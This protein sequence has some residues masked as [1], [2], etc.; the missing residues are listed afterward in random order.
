MG[1]WNEYQMSKAS[2]VTGNDTILLYDFE[3]QDMKQVDITTFK[4][5]IRPF[6]EE[7]VEKGMD[8]FKEE[9]DKDLGDVWKEV[10][11]LKK[12]QFNEPI[13]WTLRTGIADDG[14]TALNQYTAVSQPLAVEGGSVYIYDG[15]IR[16]ASRIYFIVR[17]HFYSDG[18]Y[19]GK[20]G[21]NI[22][23]EPITVPDGT[24][25]VIIE[26]GRAK[27]DL[28]TIT[29]NDIDI[30]YKGEFASFT[31]MAKGVEEVLGIPKEYTVT[32][33]DELLQLFIDL[34][35]DKKEKTVYLQGGEYDIFN[36]YKTLG[37]TSPPQGTSTSNYFDYNVF[38]PLNTNIIG[39]G[40]VV[41]KWMPTSSEISAL[42]SQIWCPVNV[43]GS[44]S[45]ENITI[46]VKN[47]R[48]C[49]HDD[50]HN[51][52]ADTVHE[53]KN[54]ICIFEAPDEGYTLH[55][56]IGFGFDPRGRYLF[57]GCTFIN[58][59][60]G[61]NHS[62]FYGHGSTSASQNPAKDS[63]NV[64]V[65]DCV[66]KSVGANTVRLQTITAVREHIKTL[67]SN[68]YISRNVL[69]TQLSSVAGAKN[70]FDLTLLHSGSPSVNVTDTTNPYEVKIYQ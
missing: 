67:F 2:E 20:A 28:V 36:A 49:I 53:Y 65:K 22:N 4:T 18:E 66:I 31:Q 41:L 19:I 69:L 58:L 47:A 13:S 39:R 63:A 44:I 30:Y 54:V 57:E 59:S 38:V 14:R 3:T 34:K 24:D 68:C 56:T 12:L 26:F 8:T 16:D 70:P 45:M 27:R 37:I 50:G 61:V 1:K 10:Y 42:E 62:A 52:N 48:Y 51:E 9:V 23:K 32:N 33:A 64:V 17:V 25:T 7:T 40:D 35:D 21:V 11:Y 5:S 29:Q 55:N 15:D 60:D 43:V 6:V 46:H